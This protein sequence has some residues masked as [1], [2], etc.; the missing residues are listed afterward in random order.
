ME[1]HQFMDVRLNIVGNVAKNGNENYGSSVQKR[2]I[3]SAFFV[4]T[5]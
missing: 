4:A 3:V 1:P 2:K 5:K